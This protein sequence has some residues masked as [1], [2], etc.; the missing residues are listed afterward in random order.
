MSDEDFLTN[1]DTI[2][3]QGPMYREVQP[4]GSVIFRF[5]TNW[6]LTEKTVVVSSVPITEQEE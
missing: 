2:T 6:V 4:D 3:V 5:R 1:E